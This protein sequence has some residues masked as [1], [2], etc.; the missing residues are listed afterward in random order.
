MKHIDVVK[1]VSDVFCEY[2][3]GII[4]TNKSTQPI[5]KELEQKHRNGEIN[6]WNMSEEEIKLQIKILLFS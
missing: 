3:K 5:C 6:L 4:K 1:L 2:P